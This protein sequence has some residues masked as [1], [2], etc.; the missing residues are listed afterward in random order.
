MRGRVRVG[1]LGAG[2]VLLLAEEGEQGDARDL[3]DLETATGNITLGVAGA[4]EAGAQD[5]IVLCGG[6]GR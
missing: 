4:T 3:D 2:L 1:P 6:G 5:L